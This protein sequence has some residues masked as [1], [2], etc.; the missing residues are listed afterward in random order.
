MARGK[1]DGERREPCKDRPL[2]LTIHLF[3]VLKRVRG[4]HFVARD[5]G[6][7]PRRCVSRVRGGSTEF[8]G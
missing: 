5:A 7:S 3:L 6:L 4:C 8:G 2:D 1:G